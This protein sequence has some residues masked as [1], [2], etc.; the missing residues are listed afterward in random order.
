[1][2]GLYNKDSSFFTV[3]S[4][5]VQTDFKNMT[6]DV[7]GINIQERMG[8]LIS[9]TLTLRERNFAYSRILR[10]G[11]EL[12]ISWGYKKHDTSPES[13]LLATTNPDQLTGQL[14]RR[15]LVARIMNPSGSCSANGEMLY[16]CNFSTL[17]WR[18][19][20]KYT[21]YQNM[22]K[23]TVISQ[24]FDEI[25]VDPLFR[26]INFRIMNE[27]VDWEYRYETAFAFLTRKAKEWHSFLRLGYTQDGKIAGCFLDAAFM[28]LSNFKNWI[29][30]AS[31]KSYHLEYMYGIN[32]VISYTWKNN[33]GENGAGDGVR[34]IQVDG[35][36]VF[37]HYVVENEQVITYR[38]N[39]EKM[40]KEKDAVGIVS[41]SSGQIKL[42]SDWL[43]TKTF[44]DVKRFFDPV[45]QSTAPQGFGYTINCEMLGDI[46]MTPTTLIT[47]GHGF[48]ER[49]GGSSTN[50]YAHTV[51]HKLDRNGYKMSAEIVDAFVISP[52]GAIL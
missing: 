50:Y 46:M 51:N 30:G 8:E 21:P 6:K 44:E 14:E 3:E 23:Q 12:K 43:N 2:I 11:V 36:I 17:G 22:T 7:V 31:G 26:E 10:N 16:N 18:G 13:L 4:A 42:I 15:G 9:G 45:S 24:V 29:T 19:D 33:E 38:L 27:H 41:G 47:F 1:M 5:D 34:A 48:P 20:S 25:G 32:N 35:K 37:E 39:V 28:P 40:Q 49:M 52:T